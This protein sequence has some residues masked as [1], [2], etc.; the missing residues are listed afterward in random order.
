MGG[1]LER[2]R[3]GEGEAPLPVALLVLD[4]GLVR[5]VQDRLAHHGLLDP[6]A[7][8]FLGPVGQWA[9]DAFCRARGLPFDGALTREAA[10][11]LL[12]AAPALPLRPG[13]DLAG[14][15]AAAMLRR[16]D[17]LC[18]HPDC[19]T[20]A[21][22]EGMG[23]DGRPTPR[24][25]DA[26]DDARL[27]LRVLP[28]GRPELAG[29][30]EATTAPGRPAVEEP[31]EPAGAP[32]LARGQHKAWVM[33]RTAIGTELEQEALVQTAPLPVTRDEDRD[34]RRAGDP[35][36]SAD[37][38][39]STSTARWTRRAIGWAPRAPAAS[40]GGRRRGTAPSWRCCAATRAGGRAMRIG[41]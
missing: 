38:S 13:P 37:S 28:G 19:V 18:R 5:A 22:V 9:L 20:I 6:P 33:G 12:E 24:R 29:A 31:A 39:S 30:W 40:S 25:P 16:G 10:A 35:P 7:D 36:C 41:S 2:F 14:R 15:V 26:F 21:Y 17:W 23:P 34:F 3:D 32:R 1:G 11:A 8:G 27:L 4:E